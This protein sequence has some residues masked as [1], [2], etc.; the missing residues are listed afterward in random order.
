MGGPVEIADCHLILC[1]P[2]S[3]AFNYELPANGSYATLHLQ[4]VKA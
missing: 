2:N 3:V 1:R 4:R